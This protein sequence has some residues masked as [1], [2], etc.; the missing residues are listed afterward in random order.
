MKLTNVFRWIEYRYY[1]MWCIRY[2]W[3]LAHPCRI[4]R[5]SRLN[6]GPGARIRFGRHICFMNHFTG[7]FYGKTTIGDQVFFQDNCHISVHEELTIGDYSIF[8]EGVSIHDENHIVAASSDP[9]GDRGFVVKSISIG[10]NVWV[11]AKATIL[12]GVHIGDNAVIGANAVVTRDVPAYTVVAGVP[13]RMIREII[14]SE[15]FMMQ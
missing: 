8:V 12:P 5:G 1:I 6:I 13:A 2:P 7:Y 9:I 14:H 15:Q 3:L 10:R 11:G 4:G